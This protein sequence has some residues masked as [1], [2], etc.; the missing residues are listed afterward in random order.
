MKAVLDANLFFST[1]ITNPLLTF[2]EEEFYEP[3][4][5]E[6]IMAEVKEHLPQV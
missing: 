6:R 2:A 4:W 1:W 3:V 5:S